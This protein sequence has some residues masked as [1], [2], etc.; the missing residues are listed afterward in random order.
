[1][2]RLK[3]MTD[4]DTIWQI[5]N[6]WPQLFTGRLL[7]LPPVTQRLGGG[8]VGGG[9]NPSCHRPRVGLQPPTSHRF[10]TGPRPDSSLQ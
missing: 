10:I 1:M 3:F 2:I 9:G 6:K 7:P 5:A 4:T 8:C